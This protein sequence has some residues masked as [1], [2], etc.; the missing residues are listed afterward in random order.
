MKKTFVDHDSDKDGYLSLEDF[1]E[2][3]HLAAKS[4]SSVV[5]NNL[6]AHH[7]RNDLKKASEIE[8]EDINVEIL[9]RYLISRQEEFFNLMLSLLDYGGKIA[10]ESWKLLN[11]LPTSPGIYYDIVTL[12]GVRGNE[13]PDWEHILDFE[14]TYK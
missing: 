5:W 3:Y 10:I 2:F 13:K 11:R 14:S 6:N 7:Y 9:A 8:E 12:K 1:V 4:R